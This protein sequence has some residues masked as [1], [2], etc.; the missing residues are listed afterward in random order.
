MER[1]LP[2]QAVGETPWPQSSARRHGF[3]AVRLHPL[4]G[5]RETPLPEGEERGQEAAALAGSGGNFQQ[6]GGQPPLTLGGTRYIYV[7]AAGRDKEIGA[8]EALLGCA[9]LLAICS[10]ILVLLY[11]I[12]Q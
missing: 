8:T 4:K 5:E 12:A 7:P 9:V 3:T 10:V 11:Y 1:E 2:Q 6:A